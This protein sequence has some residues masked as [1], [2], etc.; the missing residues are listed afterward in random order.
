MRKGLHVYSEIGPLRKVMVHKPG[1]ETANYGAD[2]FGDPFPNDC[3]YL[4]GAQREHDAFTNLL[5]GEGAEVLYLENLVAESLDAA[6]HA[7]EEFTE[8]FLADAGAAGKEGC[9]GTEINDAVRELLW[10][11]DDTLDF[12]N[13]TMS[14]VRRSELDLPTFGANSL[15][16]LEGQANDL[17]IKTLDDIWF[18]R[19]AFAV[20]GNGVNINRMYHWSRHR[21]SLYGE[22]IFKYHPEYKDSPVWIN[23]E[24]SFHT[25]GGDVLCF[26]NHTLGIGLSQRTEA[27][28]ID[29]MA[30]NMFWANDECE[31][32]TIYAF[33]LPAVHAFMHLDTV[34]TQIDHD[35]FTYFPGVIDTMRVYKITKGAQPGDVRVTEMNDTLEA[36]LKEAFDLDSV[37]LI[38]C[39]G[40][41]PVIASREQW[42]DGSNTLC[43]SPGVLCVYDRNVVTNECLDRAGYRLLVVPSGE[44]SRG[45]GGPRCA[46]MP[47]WRENL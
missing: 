2:E 25:E 17:V 16:M 43:V 1:F 33:K 40:G 27:S 11:I 34:F 42:N 6:E 5:R 23:R 20:V 31:I 37:K 3:W 14:G 30:Q 18:S 7:R 24:S 9:G 35:A 39:G 44:L 4:E 28:A 41:D 46:S 15:T 36:I 45:R 21:E 22:M 12:V 26:N 19:D 29:M 13:K 47:F 8:K 10:S 32:D 38:P